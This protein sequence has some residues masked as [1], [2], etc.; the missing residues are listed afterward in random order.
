MELLDHLE[1]ETADDEEVDAKGPAEWACIYIKYLQ[2]YKK[3]E[4]A[5]DQVVHPQKR[6]F[7]K[8][9]TIA[10]IGRLLEVWHW[11]VKLNS[12]SDYIQLDEYLVRKTCHSVN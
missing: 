5:Y 11:L 9:A 1:A 4:E 12:S 2:T 8:K 6:V 3:L 7:I 10:C